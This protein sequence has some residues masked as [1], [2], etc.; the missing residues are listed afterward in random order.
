MARVIANPF[1]EMSGKYAGGIFQNNK[2]GEIFRVQNRG[3]DFRSISK[4]SSRNLFRSISSGYKNLSSYQRGLWDGFAEFV[5]KP[6]VNYRA[7]IYSG[8]NCYTSYNNTIQNSN[9]HFKEVSI[10]PYPPNPSSS[11]GQELLVP[12]LEPGEL[13]I[14]NRGM[15]LDSTTYP[16]YIVVDQTHIDDETFFQIEL[17]LLGSIPSGIGIVELV[18]EN[19]YQFSFNFYASERLNFEGQKPANP[20]CNMLFS[21]GK[22]SYLGDGMLNAD[23]IAFVGNYNHNTLG[24]KYRY[25]ANDWI[26][27][28]AYGL[29]ANGSLSLLCNAYIQIL[30][31]E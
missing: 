29:G 7:G 4:L 16:F 1:G 8:I 17:R 19:S 22:I 12:V 13:A 6:R 26:L 3:T 10:Y 28:S 30:S 2:S 27:L 24:W 20:L 25:Q 18:D 9:L 23:G 14:Q 15:I 31:H 21:T 11:F 5:F